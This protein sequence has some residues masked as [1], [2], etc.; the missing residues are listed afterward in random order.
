MINIRSVDSK[1]AGKK[2]LEFSGFHAGG[3]PPLWL[4]STIMFS[5]FSSAIREQI[6]TKVSVRD[7]PGVK[8]D[9]RPRNLGFLCRRLCAAHVSSCCLNF[10]RAVSSVRGMSSAHLRAFLRRLCLF[11][12]L[13]SAPC[14]CFFSPLASSSHVHFS[15]LLFFFFSIVPRLSLAISAHYSKGWTVR[16]DHVVIISAN[17]LTNLFLLLLRN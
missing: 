16:G 13:H 3:E 10:L 17:L 12:F 1:A 9:R 7:E 14:I 8:S 5:F 15:L 4:A 6:N 2:E 11:Y